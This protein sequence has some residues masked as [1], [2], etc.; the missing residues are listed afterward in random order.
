MKSKLSSGSLLLAAMIVL[1]ACATPAA[2]QPA[3]GAEPAAPAPAV[4]AKTEPTAPAATAP[5]EKPHTPAP[6]AVPPAPAPD[7]PAAS[8]QP[9]AP[10]WFQVALTDVNTGQRFTISDLKGKVVL[11]E[12]L[13]VWCANCLRQQR[14]IVKLHQQLGQRAD[15]VSLALAIDPNESA[16]MLKTHAAKHGFTWRYAVAPAEAARAIARLYGDQFL[17]PPSTPMLIIDRQGG[18]HPLP[19]GVKSAAQLAEALAP[20]L[21]A[22]M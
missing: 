4:E 13:A 3:A 2:P 10:A 5:V 22:A 7:Q 12:T 14:E 20:F 8:S 21:A 1:A 16:E 11:V 9:A 17:N 19:F 15:Y 18:T 6:S